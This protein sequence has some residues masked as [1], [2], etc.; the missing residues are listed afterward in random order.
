MLHQSLTRDNANP[1]IIVKFTLRCVKD[2]LYKTQPANRLTFANWGRGFAAEP[3]AIARRKHLFPGHSPHPV[4][5]CC[6]WQFE[7]GQ[8]FSYDSQHCGLTMLGDFA[9]ICPQLY[10]ICLLPLLQ[11]ALTLSLLFTPTQTLNLVAKAWVSITCDQTVFPLSQTKGEERHLIAGQ[12]GQDNRNME[13]YH[14]VKLYRLQVPL[15][16][17][18]VFSH[19]VFCGT[20]RARTVRDY[21]NSSDA[22]ITKF[23]YS[24]CSVINYL[25]KNKT[26]FMSSW[27][28]RAQ[29]PYFRPM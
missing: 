5:C 21:Q 25:E 27:I 26:S 2:T 9:S 22:W 28:R 18:K 4:A 10:E 13:V 16:S 12:G 19:W 20:D 24:E 7:T 29:K 1:P 3:E 15:K 6:C 17:K 14:Q 8:T 11:L 23:S